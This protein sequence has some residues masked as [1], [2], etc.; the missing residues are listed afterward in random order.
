[1]YPLR[2]WLGYMGFVIFVLVVGVVTFMVMSV[3]DS[4]D[5]A[6]VIKICRDGSRIFRMQD[7]EF[8]TLR[9]GAFRGFKVENPETVC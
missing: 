4:Y 2:T 3:P 1:M 6:V 5:R 8:R 9:P 7:G